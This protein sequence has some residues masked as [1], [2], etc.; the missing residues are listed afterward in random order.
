MGWYILCLFFYHLA[1]HDFS[2]TMCSSHCLYLKVEG[3]LSQKMLFSVKIN[4]LKGYFILKQGRKPTRL[5]VCLNTYIA[6]VRFPRVWCSLF[7]FF[8]SIILNIFKLT[9]L[10]NN[11]L[12]R[13]TT[14]IWWTMSSAT[15]IL[16]DLLSSLLSEEH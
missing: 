3:M 14:S 15:T 2:T 1:V 4:C 7:L 10:L 16:R 11:T 12:C 9:K 5:F 13:T 6:N 8:F